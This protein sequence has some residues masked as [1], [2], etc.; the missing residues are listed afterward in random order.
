MP[1]ANPLPKN[2]IK[3]Y[4]WRVT[5]LDTKN[6]K[7]RLA[8]LRAFSIFTPARKSPHLAGMTFTGS[9]RAGSDIDA[10]LRHQDCSIFIQRGDLRI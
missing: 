5:I 8:K 3:A 1:N 2:L 10:D 7:R 6:T 4:D 9:G